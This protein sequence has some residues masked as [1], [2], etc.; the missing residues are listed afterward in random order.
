MTLKRGLQ[1]LGAPQFDVLLHQSL[2]LVNQGF[3]ASQALL[4]DEV[5]QGEL[6]QVRQVAPRQARRGLVRLQV[7]LISGEQVAA[8]AAFF[9]L[10]SGHQP[11]QILD[12]DMGM[13][14]PLIGFRHRPQVPVGLPARRRQAWPA[15]LP[16]P[17]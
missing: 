2:F 9:V 4:L 14:Y 13:C 12:H 8:L 15:P 11:F 7:Y 10:Q 3:D 6:L 1:A 16:I 5:V 17:R